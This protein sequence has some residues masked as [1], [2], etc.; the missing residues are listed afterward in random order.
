[1][2][3]LAGHDAAHEIERRIELGCQHEQQHQELLLTDIKYNFSVN[4]LRPAYCDD[5]PAASTTRTAPMTWREHAAGVRDIG[6]VGDAFSFDNESPLHHHYL[7]SY[8]LASRLVTC[9]EY[10]DFM[11]AG[12]YRRPEFWLAD[13]WRAVNV[14]QWQAPLY[15]EYLDGVWWQFTL[16]GLRPVSEHEPVCHVSFYEADAYAR[17]AGSRL[18]REEEWE[19][20][21]RRHAVSGN[22]RE[23]GFLHPV[24]AGEG[25][26]DDTSQLFGDVWEWTQSA[27]SPY[28]GYRAPPNEL[29][30]YNGK[31]M[32]NQLVLRGGSCVTPCDHVRPTY[33]NFFYPEDRWQLSGIRL[34]MDR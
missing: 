13:G 23:S 29:G 32:V 4:P 12:G 19:S 33:R 27:Y 28:P 22:F 17:F 9:G 26:I 18:P 21:A 1:L 31:F 20:A 7:A 8:A 5:L 10:L 15:W 2:I 16:A 3:A 30:E 14:H 6:H 24:P 11:D 34:A 25:G